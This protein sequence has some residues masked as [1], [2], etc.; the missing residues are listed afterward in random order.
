[1]LAVLSA[2]LEHSP[3]CRAAALGSLQ[4]A[5]SPG[6]PLEGCASD[7][8]RIAASPLSIQDLELHEASFTAHGES[9]MQSR[10]T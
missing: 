2:L 5:G 7:G 1:M 6:T 3:S 4:P 10:P 8:E 9:L